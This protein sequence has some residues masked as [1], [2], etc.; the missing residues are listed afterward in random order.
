MRPIGVIIFAGLLVALV[1]SQ[2]HMFIKDIANQVK[3]EL[4]LSPSEVDTT[5]VDASRRFREF[6]QQGERLFVAHDM[7][8]AEAAFTNAA[9]EDP[10]DPRPHGHLGLI[11]S[12]LRDYA[13]ALAHWRRAVELA[14]DNAEYRVNLGNAYAQVGMHAE[15]LAEWRRALEINP[16]IEAAE[17]LIRKEQG[18]GSAVIARPDSA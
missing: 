17:E 12:Q 8:A 7:Q 14:P 18:T 15:A 10:S 11:K 1:Y 4:T 16:Y 2:R 13:G 9:A 6:Y 3:K 5:G